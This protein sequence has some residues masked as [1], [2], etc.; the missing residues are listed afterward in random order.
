MLSCDAWTRQTSPAS[1]EL[2]AF[3][4]TCGLRGES[5]SAEGIRGA[6]AELRM[7]HVLQAWRPLSDAIVQCLASLVCFGCDFRLCCTGPMLAN[8]P[9]CACDKYV[10]LVVNVW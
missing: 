7:C 10:L 3:R 4:S 5:P 2:S 1:L 8:T 9:A 6:I